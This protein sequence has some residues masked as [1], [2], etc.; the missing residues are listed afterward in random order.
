MRPCR[1]H[2][3]GNSGRPVFY[4]GI[5]FQRPSLGAYPSNSAMA[6]SSSDRRSSRAVRTGARGSFLT[7]LCTSGITRRINPLGK[8]QHPCRALRRS[9]NLWRILA[10]P[11]VRLA[12]RRRYIRAPQRLP[13]PPRHRLIHREARCGEAVSHQDTICSDR[14]W[15]TSRSAVRRSRRGRDVNR[16]L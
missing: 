3:G 5:Q 1:G 8:L 12:D 14:V 7:V 2:R 6:W 13:A 9:A 16:S 15:V 4:S 11:S 10:P